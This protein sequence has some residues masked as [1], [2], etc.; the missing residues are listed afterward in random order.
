[1]LK[2]VIVKNDGEIFVV[3]IK[4]GKGCRAR[5]ITTEGKKTLVSLSF[6]IHP[7][8]SGH[9]YKD[10][11]IEV[12]SKLSATVGIISIDATRDADGKKFAATPKLF[13]IHVSPGCLIEYV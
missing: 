13:E 12:Y 4:I 7:T 6:G 2:N 8:H 5:I 3:K 9:P 11:Y 10:E 1:M